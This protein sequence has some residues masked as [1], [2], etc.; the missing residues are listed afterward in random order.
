[1]KEREVFIIYEENDNTVDLIE[2]MIVSIGLR[3][4][5]KLSEKIVCIIGGIGPEA[6]IGFM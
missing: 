5:H 6:A 1:M 3:K 2:L 4:R